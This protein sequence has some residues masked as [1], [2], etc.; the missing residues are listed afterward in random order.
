MRASEAYRL[1]T[2]DNGLRVVTERLDSVRSVALGFWVVAGSRLEPVDVGGV[3]HFIER[4]IFKGAARYSAAEIAPPAAHEHSI[5]S[6]EI[7]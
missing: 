1:S 5:G 6:L 7:A 3:S 2:L 4:L